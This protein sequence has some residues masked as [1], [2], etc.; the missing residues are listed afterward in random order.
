MYRKFLFLAGLLLASTAQAQTPDQART[1][2]IPTGHGI[3]EAPSGATPERVDAVPVLSIA[4]NG[5]GVPSA[6]GV[7]GVGRSHGL[8][9]APRF[10][11]M[12]PAPRGAKPSSG[13]SY[14]ADRHFNRC[15]GNPTTQP[16]RRK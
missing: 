15:I 6:L 14:A 9:S 3:A 2:P 4:G 7:D 10:V 11:G 5:A 16:G 1:S 13:R 12:S 8:P